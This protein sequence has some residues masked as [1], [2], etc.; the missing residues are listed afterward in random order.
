MEKLTV[1]IP[2]ESVCVRGAE[3]PK[4]HTLMDVDRPMG[5][6]PSIHLKVVAGA[7]EGDLHLNAWYGNFEYS[8][9][10]DIKKGE[11]CDVL[12]PECRTS[13]RSDDEHCV[14]CGAPMF[15]FALPKGG[16]IAACAR[17]GCHN[18]KL[19]IVDLSAQLAQ[20]FDLETRPRY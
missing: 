20:L 6:V 7:G 13:L 18:H 15:S 2:P 11:V 14:F 5:G 4:G 10:L 9:T 3:C 16:V 19:K 12:C 8:S 1:E 17:E